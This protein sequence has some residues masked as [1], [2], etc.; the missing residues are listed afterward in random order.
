MRWAFPMC[1]LSAKLLD[2][3]GSFVNFPAQEL[4]STDKHQ[5]ISSPEPGGSST[6]EL[7]GGVFLNHAITTNVRWLVRMNWLWNRFLGN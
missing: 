1:F 3:G 4:E 6:R 2:I 7:T 5:F